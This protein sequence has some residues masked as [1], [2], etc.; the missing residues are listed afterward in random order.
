MNCPVIMSRSPRIKSGSGWWRRRRLW[1]VAVRRCR[2][3]RIELLD[4]R[5]AARPG[6]SWPRHRQRF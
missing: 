1:R 6:Q 5:L 2:R 3:V 4:A